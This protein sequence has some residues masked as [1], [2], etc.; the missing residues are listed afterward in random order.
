[1]GVTFDV[2]NP[3]AVGEEP[4]A[5][6][7]KLGAHIRNIHIKEYQIYPT[8][9]GYKLVRCAIGEGVIDWKAMLALLG[10]IAPGARAQIELAALYARH[11]R[12]LEDDWWNGFPPRDVREVVPTLRLLAAHA[13]GA[14]RS[15]AD[16][17]GARRPRRGGR[18]VGAVASSWPAWSICGRLALD[19]KR[20]TTD[21]RRSHY[22]LLSPRLSSKPSYC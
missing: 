3:L 20:P 22:Q 15:L 21:D 19:L 16:A 13:R 17:L 5:F 12:L 2:V 10:E 1:M 14:D 7:R 11:I 8:P 18:A 6:A 4:F 9:S